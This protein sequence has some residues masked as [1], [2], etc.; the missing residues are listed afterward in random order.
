MDQTLKTDSGSAANQ[1]TVA[2]PPKDQNTARVII[3]PG[4][5]K[6]IQ[7]LMR[8]SFGLIKNE[9]QASYLIFGLATITIIAALFLVF[10][11]GSRQVKKN[12]NPETGT[13]II[14]GQIP[15]EI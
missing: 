11:A 12:I 9:Q 7:W 10:G 5:P 6:I 14:P 4:T 8:H 1:N 3:R 2:F 13:E 15:G